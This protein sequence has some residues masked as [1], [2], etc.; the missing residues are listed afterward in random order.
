[1]VLAAL[2]QS[3]EL[4]RPFPVSDGA[5]GY[6]RVETFLGRPRGRIAA[7]GPVADETLAE[8]LGGKPAFQIALDDRRGPAVQTDDIL[9][10]PEGRRYLVVNVSRQGRL[11][12]ALTVEAP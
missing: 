1:M 12:L 3:L 10:G 6:T 5:G 4:F 8:R 2:R 7:F 11:A 9:V